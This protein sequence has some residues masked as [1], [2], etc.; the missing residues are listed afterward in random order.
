MKKTINGV[1]Y[2]SERA[3]RLGWHQAGEHLTSWNAVLC[4]TPRAYRFFLVGNGGELTIFR[5]RQDLIPIPKQL[6]EIWAR[7]Y[8][9]QVVADKYFT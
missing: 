2:N 7:A 8:L 4:K 9:S 3:V 1:R 6:A 5:G